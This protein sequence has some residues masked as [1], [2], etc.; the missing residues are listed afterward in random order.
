MEINQLTLATLAG[1][2]H[3][4]TAKLV[5]K[6]YRIAYQELLWDDA[7]DA[8]FESLGI[9]KVPV[10]L[11]PEEKGIKKIEGEAEIKTWAAAQAH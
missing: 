5:L 7:N 1:C 6:K 9:S 11:V 4:A 3:C 10:L 8:L 2:P